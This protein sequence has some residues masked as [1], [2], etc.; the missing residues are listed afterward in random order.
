M[1]NLV[2]N[3]IMKRFSEPPDMDLPIDKYF[4]KQDKYML[5]ASDLDNPITDTSMV[6]QLNTHMAVTGTINRSVTK[7]KRQAEPEKNVEERQEGIKPI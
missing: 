7:F 3:D 4:T 1:D 5:L 2:Y 6:L